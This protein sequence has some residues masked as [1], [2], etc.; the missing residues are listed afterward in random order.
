MSTLVKLLLLADSELGAKGAKVEVAPDIA[1]AA[2]TAGNAEEV[3]EPKGKAAASTKVRLLVDCEHG[4]ANAVATLAADTAAA[5][6]KAG[7]ADGDPAAV[8]YAEKL[9]NAKA[10]DE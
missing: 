4:K 7:V 2:V 6:V 8:K 3:K 1:A 10:K 5:A 9:A